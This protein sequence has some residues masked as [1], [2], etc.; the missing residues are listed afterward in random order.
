MR[1]TKKRNNFFSK[2]HRGGLAVSQ[3]ILLIASTIAIS[4]VLG[5]QFQVV[6]AQGEQCKIKDL[7]RNEHTVSKIY[8]DTYGYSN[9]WCIKFA[10]G[11]KKN[12]EGIWICTGGS[13]TRKLNSG[14][15]YPENCEVT[16]TPTTTKIPE[17]KSTTQVPTNV[18]E[19]LRRTPDFFRILRER[20]EKTTVPEGTDDTKPTTC[21]PKE[22]TC[23]PNEKCVDDKCIPTGF[24]ASPVGVIIKDAAIVAGIYGVTRLVVGTFA[25]EAGAAA[26]NAVSLGFIAAKLFTEKGIFGVSLASLGPLAATGI[27]A[28][29]AFFIFAFSFKKTKFEVASYSCF[30]WD[31]PTGG[32]DCEKCNEEDFPCTEYRCKSLGQACELLNPGTGK[33]LCDWVNRGDVNP[34]VI[35]PWEETLTIDYK[36]IPDN[37]ISPPDRG[38]R[39]VEEGSNGCVKP[40]TPLRFGITTW[41]KDP[42]LSEPS[43][44]KIDPL[45]KSN[46]DEMNFFFGGS[47]T[48]KYNHS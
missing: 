7:G 47:S 34:P 39:I 19:I 20:D 45:R 23:K 21:G 12:S 9:D 36:Y 13:G 38:V 46:F 16:P 37:T 3:I 5:N 33:E 40:F 41:N 32:K 14:A 31:A 15:F 28:A 6:S 42:K 18:E 26:A 48:I 17:Q 4:Y 22:T 27:G 30:P 11:S 24:F 29:V 8:V 25:P 35:Q 2:S 43:K 1:K 10:G 44:C